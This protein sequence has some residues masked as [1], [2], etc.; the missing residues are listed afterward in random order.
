MKNR[1]KLL[2]KYQR[3]KV[4]SSEL[5]TNKCENYLGCV[6]SLIRFYNK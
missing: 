4:K 2:K 3:N 5:K 6:K 1:Y